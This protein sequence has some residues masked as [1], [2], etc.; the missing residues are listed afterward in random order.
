MKKLFIFLTTIIL[1]ILLCSC[2][3]SQKKKQYTVQQGD[4]I[5]TIDT[6]NET[7]SNGNTLYHYTVSTTVSGYRL[8]ITYPDNSTYWWETTSSGGYGGWSDDYDENRYVSGALLCEM[9][10]LNPAATSIHKN[11]FLILLLLVIGLFHL[12][13]PRRAWYLE[14]GWWYKDAEPSDVALGAHRLIGVVA[15]IAAIATIF[16]KM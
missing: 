9:L 11:M 15:L 7:I 10:E 13:S 16:A 4:T 2:S 12:I 5:F 3:D 14:H 1:S 8:E 6:E